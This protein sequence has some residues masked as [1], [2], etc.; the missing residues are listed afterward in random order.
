MVFQHFALLPHRTV[1][2]NVAYGLEIQ[3]MSK[4]DRLQRAAK[5]TEIVG[6]AGWEEKFPSELSGGMQQRVGLARAL[7]ADTDVLL[8]DEAFSALDPLIR[9]EM[10]DQL[11]ELQAEARQDHHLHHA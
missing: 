7:A 6:L 4:T 10:Q 1:I 9:R 11:L 3:G 5:V 2:D 8:M